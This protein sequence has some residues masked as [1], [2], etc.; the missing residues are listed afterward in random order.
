M[1]LP[2]VDNIVDAYLTRWAAVSALN[3]LVPSTSVYTGLTAELIGFPKARIMVED[4][5]SEY[6]SGAKFFMK[7]KVK[8]E[9]FILGPTNATAIRAALD[10]A[11]QASTAT[12]P[13]AGLT[14]T[15]AVGV[16]HSK[17]QPG[18]TLAPT[19]EKINNQNVNKI[20]CEYELMLEANR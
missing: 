3:S 14:V 16:I 8:F 12:G 2:N 5:P 10:A 17:R 20:A 7:F 15:N 13:S 6:T 19:G 9:T 18:G 1:S 11:F 4:G